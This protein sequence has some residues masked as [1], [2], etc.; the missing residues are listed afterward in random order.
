MWPTTRAY[1]R[2]A[3]VY[4]CTIGVPF[5][6][7]V[8]EAFEELVRRYGIRFCSAA[9]IGCGTG[10]FACYLNEC[11]GVPVYAVDKSPAMLCQARRNCRSA[12]VCF[13]QQDV[14]CLTLPSR[15]DLITAN[16]DMLN[17]L[18]TAADLRSAFNRVAGNLRPGGHF[19][20]DILTSCQPL[21]GYRVY[22]RNY[23]RV[24]SW[25]QQRVRWEPHRRLLHVRAVLRRAGSCAPVVEQITERA[26]SATE[27]GKL[28]A[29][30]AFVIR[31]VHDE[32]T[33]R[34]AV[35]CPARIIVVAQKAV[36]GSKAN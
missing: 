28:L 20:F 13:L 36:A 35:D 30:S 25:L 3:Q 31:G 32:A 15:V 24:R 5:F 19:Y 27:L 22:V 10:L 8:R 1:S 23:C 2:I 14:R 12:G 17:H 34:T 11:W 21:D 16:F 9:D 4:D 7:R 26:F 6:L 33:L 29:G 18:R